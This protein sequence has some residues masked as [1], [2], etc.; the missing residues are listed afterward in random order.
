VAD[1]RGTG[2]DGWLGNW[3]DRAVGHYREALRARAAG[4]PARA[5]AYGAAA[6]DLARAVDHAR[7]AGRYDRPDPALP[8]PAGE[9]GAEEMREQ[10]H[11]DLRR[12]YDRLVELG[13]REVTAGCDVYVD[14][15]RELYD[16]AWRDF[17]ARRDE[18]A[19]ALARA[20][21]AMTHVPVHLARADAAGTSPRAPSSPAPPPDQVNSQ[22][23]N[24]EPRDAGTRP[25]I[26]PPR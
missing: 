20:A 24:R 26:M 3:T 16:A 21:E 23:R 7:N 15:A 4:D 8:A 22:R 13:R 6:H 5:R 1:D 12:A 9:R 25:P 17:V 2:L 10:A 11:R 19:G 18:R 14:A